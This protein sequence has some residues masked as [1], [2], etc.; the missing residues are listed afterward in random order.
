MKIPV[1]KSALNDSTVDAIAFVC[2]L[3]LIV[4]FAVTWVVTR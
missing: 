3:L 1:K 4:G 2:L